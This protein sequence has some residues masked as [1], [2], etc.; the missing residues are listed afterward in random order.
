MEEQWKKARERYEGVEIPQE[1][2]GIV[3]SAIRTGARRGRSRRTIRRSLATTLAACA[4]F[5]LLVNTSPEF[6]GA[7]DQVPILGQLARIVTVTQ[8]SWE[9]EEHLI[10]VRLPALENT[11]N[12][13]LEQRINT[14]IRACIDEVIAQAEERAR[15]AKEAYVATGG[16]P[17]DFMPLIINVDYQVKCQNE[18]YLSFIVEKT[19][20]LASAYTEFYTYNIDLTTGKELTLRD[21]LGN[22]YIELA[23]QAV[24]EGI[25]QRSQDPDNQY[26]DT[27]EDG[28]GFQSIA[29]DQRF[30]LNERGN[31]VILF[32]KYEIAPG[33]M[34]AQEFEVVRP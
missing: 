5:A 31:P 9:D 12:T 1:L 29:P 23:N 3:S 15:Q 2:D 24:R 19:E 28:L 14:E 10:D 16:D 22:D 33:Y 13:D 21:V 32:E 27:D 6:A 25:A 17:E 8:Y 26:F 20:T 7:V 18:Q 4:C 34:G 11:G 30:Y